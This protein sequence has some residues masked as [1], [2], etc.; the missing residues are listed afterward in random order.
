MTITYPSAYSIT[1]LGA[2]ISPEMDAAPVS[3]AMANANAAYQLHTPSIATHVYTADP[4]L[5]RQA[6]FRVP[7]KPSADDLSYTF[8]HIVRTGTGTTSVTIT[9]E[10]QTSGG[11]WS[12]IYGPTATA[13][14]ASSVEDITTTATIDPLTDEVRITYDRSTDPTTYDSVTIYPAANSPSARTDAGFWPYDDGLL[15]ASGA[16]INTELVNR[17]VR[18]VRAV[19]GDRAQCVLSFAQEDESTSGANVRWDLTD[20][21][22]PGGEWQTFGIVTASTPFWPDGREITVAALCSVDGGTTSERVRVRTLGGGGVL[23][24]GDG[25]VNRGTLVCKV[26]EPGT[27]AASVTL[28]VEARAASARKTW[29]HAV[30][31]WY[32]PTPSSD[33]LLNT[34]APPASIEI[35]AACLRTVETEAMSP[36]AQ[37]ALMYEGNTTGLTSRRWIA[38][39]PP[40][41]QRMRAALARASQADIF[42][43]GTAQTDSTV[44]TTTTS[45]VPASPAAKTVTVPSNTYGAEGYLNIDGS[46]LQAVT[47]WSSGSFDDTSPSASVDRLLQVSEGLAPSAEVVEVGYTVGCGLHYVRVR[48]AADYDDI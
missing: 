4:D 8:R 1:P 31:G 7:L 45:G 29:L 36:W 43:G 22:T 24:D 25:N 11:G 18:N 9:I 19:L 10:E 34:V 28:I 35:L 23:L 16:P 5:T 44:E 37:P 47:R 39:V 26:N 32:L 12:T 33:L 20:S 41:C 21:S 27:L 3:T 38:R 42:T 17:P 46:E 14:S 6:R 40:A 48:P 2:L 13:V 15:T 30:T